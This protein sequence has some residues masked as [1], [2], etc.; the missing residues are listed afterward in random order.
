M[1]VFISADME[2]LS[3]VVNGKECSGA[4]KEYPAFCQIM[5]KEVNAAIEGALEAGATE[6]LVNDSH[7]DG[8]NIIPELLNPKALLSRGQPLPVMVA[9]LD[10]SYQALF[11]VGYH[12]KRGTANA[13]LNHTYRGLYHRIAV[14]GQELGELGMAAA[15][16]GSF[17]VP[18]AFASGDDKLAGEARELVPG[19]TAVVVKYATSVTTAKCL[20]PEAA[21]EHI[22]A[23]AKQALGQLGAV[24]PFVIKPPLVLE[25]EYADYTCLDRVVCL[26]GVERV[27]GRSIRCRFETMPALINFISVISCIT[28]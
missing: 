8:R 20:S 27:G 21:R 11:L 6:I 22:R 28:V 16:A 1:K 4:E 25:L 7:G 12:A 15:Y 2:G 9:G 13:I 23:G 19:V 18:L 5:T 24:K 3:A 17:G 10:A 14:N 26:P